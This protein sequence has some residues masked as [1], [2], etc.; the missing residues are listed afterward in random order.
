MAEDGAPSQR[1]FITKG[2]FSNVLDICTSLDRDG[3]EVLAD[4]ERRAELENVF[5][6][7]SAE[8]F[9]VLAIATRNVSVKAD[10][11]RDDEREMTFRGFLSSTTLPRQT[12]GARSTISIG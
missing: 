5:K 11:D 8:G 12:R 7:K 6:A 3:V 4:A 9:R 1:L 2:A 10:Y